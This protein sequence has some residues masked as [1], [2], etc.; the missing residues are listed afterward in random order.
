MKYTIIKWNTLAMIAISAL[1][2]LSSCSDNV[3]TPNLEGYVYGNPAVGEVANKSILDLKNQFLSITDAYDGKTF[4]NQDIKIR[5]I[6]T[7]NDKSGNIYSK[8]VIQDQTAA[9]DISINT[10]GL[11]VYLPV[12]QEV[13][14]SCKELYFGARKNSKLPQLGAPDVNGFS[15]MNNS[16]WMEHV[17]LIGT[18][19]EKKIPVPVTIDKNWINNMSKDLGES[20]Y[21][22]TVKAKIAEADGIKLFAPASEA[23]AGYGVDR[24][25][26]LRDGA[27]LTCRISQYANFANTVMP[28]DSVI[29]YGI[30]SRYSSDWQYVPRTL[31]DFVVIK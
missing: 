18:P 2:A 4:I 19:D 11:F 15:S 10:N 24:T 23:D 6:V 22:V 27:T 17:N 12:G 1:G 14:V 3:D 9:L 8:I 26:K 30:I 29:V 16:I 20:K 21:A 13:V 28:T 31:E 25:L 7:A 5:G